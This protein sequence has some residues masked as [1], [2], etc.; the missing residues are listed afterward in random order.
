MAASW[1]P[2]GVNSGGE[3]NRGLS[4]VQN[5]ID[6]QDCIHKPRIRIIYI[7]KVSSVHIPCLVP[8]SQKRPILIFPRRNTSGSRHLRTH[9]FPHIILFDMHHHRPCLRCSY[10]AY[11]PPICLFQQCNDHT[12]TFTDNF[13]AKYPILEFTIGQL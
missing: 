10:S 5:P 12:K 1:A 2:Q 4:I 6:T 8:R 3:H 9:C 13:V 7:L 11:L